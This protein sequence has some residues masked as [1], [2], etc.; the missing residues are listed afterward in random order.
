MPEYIQTHTDR[1]DPLR[2]KP[3]PWM[4]GTPCATNPDAWFPDRG[5]NSEAVKKICWGCEAREKCLAYALEN[6][7]D[8][9]IWG[10]LSAAERAKLRPKGERRPR[11]TTAGPRISTR[12]RPWS[13]DDEAT[14]LSLAA[15]GLDQGLIGERLG[16]SRASVYARLHELR[17]P[18]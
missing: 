15:E 5:G 18:T 17:N 8:Q 10:A 13:K 12:S 14:L 3:E 2:I 6:N 16:R 11:K 1:P 9:G 7:E 4:Q